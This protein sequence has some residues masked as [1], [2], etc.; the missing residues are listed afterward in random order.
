MGFIFTAK[1]NTHIMTRYRDE[2]ETAWEILAEIPFNSDRKR[3]SLIVRDERG[4]ILLMTK[5]A[6]SIM[7]PLVVAGRTGIG[8][9]SMQG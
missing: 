2:P 3:M 7:A 9:D 4:N 5:G 6:D 8:M 1:T